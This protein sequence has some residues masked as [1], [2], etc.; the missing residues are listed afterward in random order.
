MSHRSWSCM[1]VHSAVVW[2]C[3]FSTQRRNHFKTYLLLQHPN[4]PAS[5][6]G[7]FIKRHVNQPHC[8]TIIISYYSSNFATKLPEG[9]SNND[10]W[11]VMM[12]ISPVLIGTLRD[13]LV[14]LHVFVCVLET[15]VKLYNFNATKEHL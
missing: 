9:S 13:I 6:K 8:S 11:L 5:R 15:H 1:Y 10:V 2:G 3:I 4:V 7:F 14:K 12:I